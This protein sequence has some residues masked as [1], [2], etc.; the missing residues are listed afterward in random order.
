M[1]RLK[2]PL[3]QE[4]PLTRD[5]VFKRDISLLDL[6]GVLRESW[7]ILL[8][9]VLLCGLIFFAASFLFAER[10]KA[11]ILV[12]PAEVLEQDRTLSGSISSLAAL[13]GIG[14]M[15][16]GNKKD[17]YLAVLK[18][19]HFLFGFIREHGLMPV[20]FSDQWDAAKQAWL[21][22]EDPPT[23]LD[24][25]NE[26]T[27]DVLDITEDAMTGLITIAISW[28]D[29]TLAAKWANAIVQDVNSQIQDE[30]IQTSRKNLA[31]LEEMVRQTT[32]Q[33]VRDALYAVIESEIKQSMLANATDQFA[34]K[35]IDPAIK[36]EQKHFPS[37]A[38]FLA[39]GLFL[40]LSIAFIYMVLRAKAR[41]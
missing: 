10:Y 12:T 29:P 22:A 16:G 28:T 32:L 35:I 27:D 23:L 40:G 38:A 9:L 39:I 31:Y 15:P 1:S 8:P 21:P 36:P 14:L 30:T 13:T 7:Y 4:P 2:D 33:P 6:Y 18:S 5:A 34:F 17:E 26:F 37:R 41:R 3:T 25:Y 24:S 19:K 11:E 20:L